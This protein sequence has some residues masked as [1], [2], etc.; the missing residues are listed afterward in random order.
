MTVYWSTAPGTAATSDFTP[1]K[2]KTVFTAAQVSKMLSVTV[3]Q[4]TSGEPDELMYLVVAGVLGGE[5]HRERGTGT[6][7]N[8]DPGTGVRLG[9]SDALIVEGD[10]GTRSLVVPITLTSPATADV[11]INWSTQG[12]GSASAGLDYTTRGGTVKIAT[13]KRFAYL[14]IPILPDTASEGAETFRIVVNTATNATVIDGTGLV[15][16][17]DDD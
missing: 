16:I 9:V 15:T 13:T 17:R 3:K 1:T 11:L 6:I 7:V 8:D 14:T 2:G 4:D 5:N 10:L 12:T